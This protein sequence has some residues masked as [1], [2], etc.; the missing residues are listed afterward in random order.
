MGGGFL[1]AWRW[2]SCFLEHFGELGL[3]LCRADGLPCPSA[4]SSPCCVYNS[5]LAAT[6]AELQ[7][8]FE[9]YG[10]VSEVHLVLDRCDLPALLG[11]CVLAICSAD[12]CTH[13]V[14]VVARIH[15]LVGMQGQQEE[16]GLC[17]CITSDFAALSAIPCCVRRASK[18]SKG[19]ALVQFGDPQDAVKAHAGGGPHSAADWTG[20]G[21]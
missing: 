6:E 1:V 17:T 8:L 13:S 19:F 5:F 2:L 9:Q 11:Q 7:E 20:W 16:Q 18:K 10:S 3:C 12:Q 14:Q 15:R 4:A 21:R